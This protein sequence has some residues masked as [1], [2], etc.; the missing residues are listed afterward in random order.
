MYVQGYENALLKM[1]G[2]TTLGK[3]NN[4]SNKQNKGHNSVNKI[5]FYF[6]ETLFY[7]QLEEFSTTPK[8]FKMIN[9]LVKQWIR[10]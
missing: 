3:N 2:K 7:K 4:V 8:K 10:I 5:Q 1:M 6:L 9:L